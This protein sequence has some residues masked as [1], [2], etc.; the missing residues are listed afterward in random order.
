MYAREKDPWTS[1]I[2][3]DPDTFSGVMKQ[4]LQFM[5]EYG[6]L[7]DEQLIEIWRHDLPESKTTD[8]SIR[9]RRSELTRYNFITV[10]GNAKTTRGRRCILWGINEEN[11]NGR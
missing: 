1:H 4:I 10:K 3:V 2:A 8:Q 11:N 9:S 5:R 6:D 7:T